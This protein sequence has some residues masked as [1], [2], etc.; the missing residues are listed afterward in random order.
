M[1]M[2]RYVVAVS[3]A[4]IALAIGDMIENGQFGR[5]GM[6]IRIHDS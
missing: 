3:V 2:N 6:P 5:V 4:K 1:S